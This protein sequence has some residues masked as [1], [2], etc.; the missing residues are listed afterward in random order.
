MLEPAA[1]RCSKRTRGNAAV[2]I[3]RAVCN[4]RAVS[5]AT[6]KP[7]YVAK[8]LCD[9]VSMKGVSLVFITDVLFG[10]SYDPTL[11]CYPIFQL[12]F[13]PRA[14][15]LSWSRTTVAIAGRLAPTPAENGAMPKS[16]CRV[17]HMIPRPRQK[18]R[19]R[20]DL[21]Q[22]SRSLADIAPIEYRPASRADCS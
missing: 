10:L 21:G 7:N 1:S 18:T 3:V 16:K 15:L 14:R 8:P 20:H 13:V 6:G 11:K 17:P 2:D 22:P 4:Q 19:G 12:S 9:A 5:P